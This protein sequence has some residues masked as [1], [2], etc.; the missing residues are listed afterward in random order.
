MMIIICPPV[1]G[2]AQ[3]SAPLLHTHKLGDE[4]SSLRRKDLRRYYWDKPVAPL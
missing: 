4:S 1:S 2:A 3:M